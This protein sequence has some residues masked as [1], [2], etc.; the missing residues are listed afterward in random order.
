M[1]VTVYVAAAGIRSW[2]NLPILLRPAEKIHEYK[3]FVI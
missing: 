1:E 2:Q 3:N